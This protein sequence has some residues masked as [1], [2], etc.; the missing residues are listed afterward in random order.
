MGKLTVSEPE[1]HKGIYLYF[2]VKGAWINHILLIIIIINRTRFQLGSDLN[3]QIINLN[4][5]K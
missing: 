2:E 3:S 5:S 1:S 4:K